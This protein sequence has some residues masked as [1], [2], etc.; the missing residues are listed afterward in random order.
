MRVPL[1]TRACALGR[2]IH[3]N[4]I[5]EI[6]DD[7]FAPTPALERVSLWGQGAKLTN[8]PS[9][10]VNCKA[11]KGVQVSVWNLQK[12]PLNVA[13]FKS[14]AAGAS[15]STDVEPP[16]TAQANKVQRRR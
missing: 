5:K 10:L 15:A 12:L 11:L 3:K 1:V 9:S 13:P 14:E 2:R 16:A 8:L 4:N 6:K 7:Y